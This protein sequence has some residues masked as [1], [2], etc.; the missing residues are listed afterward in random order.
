[1]RQKQSFLT[2]VLMTASLALMI[3]L[4]LYLFNLGWILIFGNFL[5]NLNFYIVCIEYIIGLFLNRWRIKNN[6]KSSIE[7]RLI[8]F[9]KRKSS[10]QYRQ[11]I[12]D[13]LFDLE[14]KL[15]RISKLLKNLTET[16]EF[17]VSDLAI[18]KKDRD[19]LRDQIKKNKNFI[20]K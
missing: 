14:K 4:W 13:R 7:K 20:N 19:L 12:M 11:K 17:V 16:L 1:M 15:D 6:Y 5:I 2:Y 18:P 8:N 10:D 9:A 3:P